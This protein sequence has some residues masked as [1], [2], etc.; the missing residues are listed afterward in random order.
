MSVQ[1]TDIEAVE[2]NGIVRITVALPAE[3]VQILREYAVKHDTTMTEALR[4]FISNQNYLLQQVDEGGK[5]LI[6]TK[7]HKLQQLALA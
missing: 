2:E 4:R 6:E 7:D 3:A 5:V 1:A